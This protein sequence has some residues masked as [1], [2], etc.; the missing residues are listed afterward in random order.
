MRDKTTDSVA[1][2]AGSGVGAALAFFA[3]SAGSAALATSAGAA[4]GLALSRVANEFVGRALATRERTR[5]DKALCTI[6]DGISA[7]RMHGLKVRTDGF[8][9]Q[10]DGGSLSEAVEI[11][12]H[13]LVKC[14]REPEEK[15]IH[16][17]GQMY[18]SIAFEGSVSAGLAHNM[19]KTADEMT[20]RQLCLLSIAGTGE[21]RD[22]LRA[23]D[24]RGQATF[25]TE[26]WEVL[27]EVLPLYQR[28]LVNFGGEVLFGPTDVK[29]G[30]MVAQ[31]MGAMMFDLMRLSTIPREDLDPIL[32]QLR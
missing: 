7:R 22:S 31:G 3:T 24:Y 4:A 18:A 30:A 12:E 14:Q 6:R 2:I 23:N 15:K 13:T 9:D 29:P 27:Y 11:A 20:Y 5:L 26:L 21:H 10:T 32:H 8:F 16:Y 25:P 17:I 19:I 1:H 28:G